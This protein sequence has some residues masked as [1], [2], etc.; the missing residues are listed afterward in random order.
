M[1]T[2]VSLNLGVLGTAIE[3]VNRG[4]FVVVPADGVAADS[5]DAAPAILRHSLRPIAWLSTATEVLDAWSDGAPRP[6]GG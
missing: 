3:A 1:L 5:A 6:D 4:D 2:G